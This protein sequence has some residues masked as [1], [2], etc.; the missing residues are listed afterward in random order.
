MALTP[1]TSASRYVLMM[2]QPDIIKAHEHSS[3]H[4]KEIVDSDICGCFYCQ[5]IFKPSEIIEWIDEDENEI[6]QT[7]LCPFCGIDSVIGDKSIELSEELLMGM[8]EY[9]F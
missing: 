9:W 4:Y 5:T 7:A 2:N 1:G 6:G 8:K 3:N